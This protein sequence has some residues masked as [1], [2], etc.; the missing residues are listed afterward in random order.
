M[1]VL[2]RLLTFYELA[3]RKLKGPLGA[4]FPYK[5]G[6]TGLQMLAEFIAR[7]TRDGMAIMVFPSQGSETLTFIP[8]GLKTSGFIVDLKIAQ[9]Q[10]EKHF[11][12]L[13]Q[14]EERLASGN[15]IAMKIQYDG[16]KIELFHIRA[17]FNQAV[18]VCC[19]DLTYLDSHAEILQRAFQIVLEEV[20]VVME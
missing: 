5:G 20:D 6:A 17:K 19:F 2:V 3:L 11:V 1:N 7:M 8:S 16:N 18:S 9:L 13:L 4:V 14:K 12:M 15:Y 10:Q